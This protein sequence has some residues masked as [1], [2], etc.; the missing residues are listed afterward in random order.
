MLPSAPT[1]TL[2]RGPRHSCGTRQSTTAKAAPVMSPVSDKRS[3][4]AFTS[5]RLYYTSYTQTNTHTN[6]IL[7]H[8]LYT[9]TSKDYLSDHPHPVTG[10]CQAG[11][12][13]YYYYYYA[14]KTVFENETTIKLCPTI[15]H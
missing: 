10:T 11:I 9:M 2:G 6:I 1:A 14:E 13:P 5:T 12:Y 15:F 8:A 7:V 4:F 3:T